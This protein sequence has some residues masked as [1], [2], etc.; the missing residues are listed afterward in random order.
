MPARFIALVVLTVL[1]ASCRSPSVSA[2][3]NASRRQTASRQALGTTFRV[4]VY[5]QDSRAASSGISAAFERLSEVDAALGAGLGALNAS[6]EGRPVKVADDLFAL[7]QHAQRFAAATRGAFDVTRGPYVELWQRAAAEGRAP[8][9][10]EIEAARLRVGWDKLRLDAIEHTVTL[11]VPG[12]R[13]ELDGIARGYATDAMMQQLS[14]HGCDASRV[15]AGE[16]WFFGAPPPG[17]Q[18]TVPLRGISG[19]RGPRAMPVDRMAVAF[20]GRGERRGAPV[21]PTSGRVVGGAARLLVVARSA[22]SAECVATAAE[23]LGPTGADRLNRAEP[24]AKVT[25]GARTTSPRGPSPRAP[26]A[27]GPSGGSG[28]LRPE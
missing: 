2:A 4:T 13:L 24:G 23:V 6:P 9:Q 8:S 1:A 21:D 12:M 28:R 25:F 10:A 18:W 16:V 3:R 19:P 22:A 15:E 26:S 20:G 27:G 11:T 5:S 7:L 14:L 17:G